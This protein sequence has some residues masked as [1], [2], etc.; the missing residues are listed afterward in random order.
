[1][2]PV[3]TIGIQTIECDFFIQPDLLQEQIDRSSRSAADYVVQLSVEP[4]VTFNKRVSIATKM[5]VGLQDFYGVSP[6]CH[7]C[8]KGKGLIVR[9][10]TPGNPPV[11][12]SWRISPVNGVVH[13]VR[14]IQSATK[15]VFVPQGRGG[16]SVFAGQRVNMGAAIPQVASSLKLMNL[17]A[18]RYVV[19]GGKGSQ[20]ALGVNDLVRINGLVE[21]GSPGDEQRRLL[22]VQFAVPQRA[23]LTLEILNQIG[24]SPLFTMR[25]PA[26]IRVQEYGRVNCCKRT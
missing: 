6:P 11:Q 21:R 17:A 23:E 8:R 9:C 10:P 14:N 19:V 3:V 26:D 5:L 12:R 20:H 7:Q 18:R 15:C 25:H 22:R 2:H 13:T 1:M 16:I 4:V 24:C